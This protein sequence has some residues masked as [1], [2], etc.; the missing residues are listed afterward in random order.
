MNQRALEKL[1]ETHWRRGLTEA[2]SAELAAQWAADPSAR[3]AWTED[4]ALNQLLAQ[5]PE[6]PRAASNFTAQVLA[7]AALADAGCARARARERSPLGWLTRWLPRVA[8]A[9]LVLGASL[10]GY[11]EVNRRQQQAL[12]AGAAEVSQLVASRPEW[13][14]DYDAIAA[15]GRAQQAP[16]PKADTELLALLQ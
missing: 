4:V 8:V 13:F 12:V 10:A 14:A 2:E 7:Q 6:P 15:V 1:R 5:L 9:S 11:H 16:Q 3:A